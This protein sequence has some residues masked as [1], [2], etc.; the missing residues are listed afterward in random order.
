MIGKVVIEMFVYDTFLTK[1]DTKKP[2]L[3]KNILIQNLNWT[4]KI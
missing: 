2:N 1:Y 3:S 4:R